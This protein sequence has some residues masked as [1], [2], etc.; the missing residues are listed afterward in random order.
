MIKKIR[1]FNHVFRNMKIGLERIKKEL[2]KLDKSANERITS[3]TIEQFNNG[4][5]KG[6]E[7]Y[8]KIWNFLKAIKRSAEREN[9]TAFSPLRKNGALTRTL[10]ENIERW[11]EW[12]KDMFFKED[13]NPEGFYYEN[14]TWEQDQEKI[15][16]DIENENKNDTK[17]EKNAKKKRKNADLT[18]LLRENQGMKEVLNKEIEKDEIKK[19]IRSLKNNKSFGEDRIPGEVFKE[20][21]NMMTEI[22]YEIVQ[23]MTEQNQLPQQLVHGI[24]T[25][26][27]K[28]KSKTETNNYRP[29]C[30][31][32]IAY[33]IITIIICI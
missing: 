24:I 2:G 13:I 10:S 1:E 14:E 19:A 21:E 16:N 26:L 20:N 23:N 30:L 32:N 27:H 8:K 15:E 29:I 22:L 12:V 4:A 18:K 9:E 17:D 6:P 3:K 33:K 31:L 7:R 28:K 11:E 25:L 5:K